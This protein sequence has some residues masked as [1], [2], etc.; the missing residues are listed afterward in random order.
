MVSLPQQK[1][2]HE[3]A[4]NFTLSGRVP[5][6]SLKYS[7]SQ[8]F[9]ARLLA[10]WIWCLCCANCSGLRWKRGLSEY[11]LVAV[12]VCHKFDR[13]CLRYSVQNSY[14]VSVL[15][16]W[17]GLRIVPSA[18]GELLF[19]RVSSVLTWHFSQNCKNRRNEAMARVYLHCIRRDNISGGWLYAK[20]PTCSTAQLN[21]SPTKPQAGWIF[22]YRHDSSQQSVHHLRT[23]LSWET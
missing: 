12:S 10:G 7:F 4:P 23:L 22:W 13:R 15:I 19:V 11:G 1:N 6:S 17:R 3:S 16:E 18:H 2:I 20:M 14:E 8:S 9:R 21:R 5:S